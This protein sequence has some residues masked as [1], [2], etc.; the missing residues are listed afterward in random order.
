MVFIYVL[1]LEEG[2][3]YVEKT[4]NPSFRLDSHFQSIGSEWTR[5]YKP[6]AI[7]MRTN[8]QEFIWTDMG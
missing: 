4:N 8:I 2:K 6:A 5:K 3:Y 1:Q 7:M